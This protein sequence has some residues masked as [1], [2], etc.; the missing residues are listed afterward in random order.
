MRRLLRFWREY[1]HRYRWVYLAGLVFLLATNVLTVAIPGFVQEAVDSL[2][3]TQDSSDA[4]GWAVAIIAAGVGIIIVRT[5]SRTLFFNPGR[6]IEFRLKNQMFEHLLELP[7]A[8]YD[9]MRPGEIISR[10]TNDTNAVRALIGY[11]GLA[12]F[13]VSLMLVL[14]F[15]QML[16]S[17]AEITLVIV[18]PLVVAAIALRYAIRAMFHIVAAS[19]RQIAMLSDRILESYNGVAVIHAFNAQDGASARFD[20]A[21]EELLDLALRLVRIT[22]WL[23]PV[24]SVV[25][26]ISVVILLYVG[27]ERV[28]NDTMTL[29]QLA[30]FAQY[31][32]ILVNG[33]IGL[34]WLVN[35]VQRGYISLG[36]V[37]EVVDAP[38]G[39]AA[40][41]APMPASPERG[42]RLEVE[43]L[44]FRYPAPP[45]DEDGAPPEG[46]RPVVLRD[47]SFGV[48]AGET[49]GIFG[50]TG[51]GKSTLMRLL[52]RVYDVPG[53]A[54]RVDGVDVSTVP[55]RDYWRSVAYVPQ[56]AFLFSRSIRDNV[57]LAAPAGPRDAREDAKVESAAADAALTD[58]LDAL[59]DGLDTLVGERG[60]T[61][62]GGQRQRAA[63]A[64]AFYRD[65]DLL[66]L[67][68]VMSAVDHATEKRLIDAVYRRKGGVTT[69]VVSHR[70][71]VLARADR[72]LVLEDG[73]VIDQGTHDELVERGAGPY[74]R[75]WLL[76]Q[77]EDS[78]EG[79]IAATGGAGG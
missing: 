49:L 11:G 46:P 58:D 6:T 50:V 72:V 60:V 78:S 17:D 40:P 24:V 52:A 73:R 27:G 35:A 3:A 7:T 2:E 10:G 37:N 55:V 5:L 32:A 39:R 19:Q 59:P 29:G 43:G 76:Q 20:A 18:A 75:A 57:G 1:A 26:N 67:D 33:L 14:T 79:A 34:G 4:V 16:I 77:D 36:R 71:S 41:S 64:R 68:D 45:P 66:L 9:R 44:S 63:L 31:I 8:F 13:N 25:G 28:M 51:S 70:V 54:I 21:N 23:L 15:G 22:S 69:V 42:H 38:I 61:L 12:V 48:A 65:F 30:A 56:E 74:H 62:S 47:V 53:G